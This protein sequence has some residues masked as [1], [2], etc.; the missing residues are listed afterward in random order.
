MS[1]PIDAIYENGV[2]RPLQPLSLPE[3][4]QVKVTVETSTEANRRE[5][6]LRD[7]Q[8]ELKVAEEQ[9]DLGQTASFDA[10][11]TKQRLRD[12]LS[13]KGIVG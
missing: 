9:S 8:A 3:H 6:Q 11:A 7:L 5:S 12:R 4:A 13:E 10:E 2:L 1:E